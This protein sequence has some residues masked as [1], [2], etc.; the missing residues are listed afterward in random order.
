VPSTWKTFRFSCC[1]SWVEAFRSVGCY[2]VQEHVATVFPVVLTFKALYRRAARVT[3][4][5]HRACFS[6]RLFATVTKNTSTHRCTASTTS[7]DR[8][9]SKESVSTH[10][11]SARPRLAVSFASSR[12]HRC[13]LVVDSNEGLS[14]YLP[15]RPTCLH[16]PADDPSASTTPQFDHIS[17]RLRL[18]SPVCYP[19]KNLGKR[20]T[21]WLTTLK[22]YLRHHFA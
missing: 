7:V 14:A 1:G 17:Y 2:L 21:P 20:C 18:N 22:P 3:I 16:Q 6:S 15:T 11:T 10:Q 4:M 5:L 13:T 8:C 19:N 9:V 12:S